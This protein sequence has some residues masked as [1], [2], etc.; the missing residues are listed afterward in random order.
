[1]FSQDQLIGYGIGFYLALKYGD[2]LLFIALLNLIVINFGFF[3]H[4]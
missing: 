3:L 2:C 4:A 1:M